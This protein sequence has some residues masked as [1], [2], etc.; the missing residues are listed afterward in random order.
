MA[1]LPVT[2]TASAPAPSAAPRPSLSL[3]DT[4]AL[5]V[6]TVIGVGI[7][8]TPSPVA[9]FAGSEGVVVLAWVA[10]GLISLLGALCYAELTTSYPHPG[11]DYHFLRRAFGP[12]LSF[13]FGWARISVIQP[14]SIA[15]L[16]FVLGDYLGTLLSLGPAGP[17]IWAALAITLLTGINVLGIRHGKT[18]QNVFTTLEVLG[19]L[20]V[21]G[22]G[23]MVAPAPPAAGASPAVTPSGLG[24]VMVFVLLTYGGWNEAAY[25]S[26]EVRDPARN[27]VRALVL[28]IVLVTLLYVGLNLV[29]L[30]SLGLQGTASSQAVA[31]DLLARALGPAAAGIMALLVAIAAFTSANAAVLTGAR[32][33]FAVGRDVG[34]F[35]FLGQWNASTGT[36]VN[37]VLA[38]SAVALALVL[39]GALTRRGFETMVEYTAPVFWFF[40]LLTVASLFVLRRTDPHRSRPFRVPGYP[41]TPAV[42]CLVAVYLLYSSVRYAGVGA[43]VGLVV[44]ASGVFVMR[45]T[46]GVT[47]GPGENSR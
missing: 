27:M 33:A 6:G 14:G 34:A 9:S 39:L 1:R 3:R 10:G 32:S 35:R 41:A 20:L 18:T 16:A 21:A 25:V 29:Y 2:P 36:P 24:L 31:A 42:F 13:L 12:R 23:L 46:A 37:A 15:L 40:F 38:Q 30:R 4:I 19:V 45:V 47:P 22:A 8:R 44:L 17:A 43:L 7:F 26:A 5:I 28:S 11:G